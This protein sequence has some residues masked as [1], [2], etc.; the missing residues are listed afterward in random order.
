MVAHAIDA[1]LT[2]Y[3]V[4][5]LLLPGTGPARSNQLSQ[6]ALGNVDLV[7][8]AFR[9]CLIPPKHERVAASARRTVVKAYMSLPARGR[10]APEH[11]D[12]A[13]AQVA[14]QVLTPVEP[15]AGGWAIRASDTGHRE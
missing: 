13:F 3:G 10:A 7:G 9:V 6:R 1:S 12:A 5:A 4:G 2:R 11:E 8:P 15:R 14:A